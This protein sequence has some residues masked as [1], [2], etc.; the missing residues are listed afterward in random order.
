MSVR[1]G[2]SAAPASRT[3]TSSIVRDPFPPGPGY[4]V[5]AVEASAAGRVAGA[6]AARSGGGGGRDRDPHVER[7]ADPESALDP[8]PSPDHVDHPLHDVEPEPDPSAIG[9][10]AVAHLAER[11]EDGAERGRRDADA[12][13]RDRELH[14]I[15]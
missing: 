7:R 6:A 15:A 4:A 2:R 9:R 5:R 3:R 8:Y 12:G 11:L 1:R 10:R 14:A 13:V